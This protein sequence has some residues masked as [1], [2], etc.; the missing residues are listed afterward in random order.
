MRV[1]LETERLILRNLVPED[2]EADL[3][4]VEYGHR[5]DAC[6]AEHL[7]DMLSDCR[8]EGYSPLICSSF[9]ER[10]KQERLFDNDVR[11][12]MYSGMSPKRV[13]AH[14]SLAGRKGPSALKDLLLFATSKD[15]I[16]SPAKTL[17]SRV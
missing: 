4:H 3:E 5:M 7:S 12:F 15:V 8:D 13:L 14:L 11:R 17:F 1:C 9:R 10:S 6:A 16:S 2:Y